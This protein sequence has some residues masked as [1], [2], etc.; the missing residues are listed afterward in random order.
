MSESGPKRRPSG[1]L[2]LFFALWPAAE[3]RRAL[4]QA[5][6][7]AVAASGA[8]PIPEGNLHLTLA[9]LGNV[10][11]ARLGSLRALA[12]TWV[13][14]ASAPPLRLRFETLQ[15]WHRPQILCATAVQASG[16]AALAV[17]I[18]ESARAA[19]FSPD[20]KPFQAHVT[21]ARQVAQAPEEQP[22]PP[23]SWNCSAFALVVS[24][25]GAESG[26][27]YSVLE[28]YPLD[29]PDNAHK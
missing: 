5:A 14:P 19:G 27:V 15:H 4:T 17:R 18:R 7:A 8:R 11:R 29:G 21:V 28:T 12:R 10:E 23:V 3:E 24:T 2:R 25:T 16:A 26:S 9:F 20:L 6:A 13:P 1:G 22:M